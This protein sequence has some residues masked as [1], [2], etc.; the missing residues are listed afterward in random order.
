M[1]LK[2]FIALM[3]A[4]IGI[5]IT[6]IAGLLVI[7][8]TI[9]CSFS[10]ARVNECIIAGVNLSHSFYDLGMMAA[11]GVLAVPYMW[12]YLFAG[13]LIFK[14]VSFLYSVFIRM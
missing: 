12:G 2:T 9:D 1:G 8:Q 11:W 5:W 3:L 13:W 7:S 10:E 14:I 6:S 4:P